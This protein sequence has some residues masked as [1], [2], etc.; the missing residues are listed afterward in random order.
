MLS[1][2]LLYQK[3]SFSKRQAVLLWDA[4][5]DKI[6]PPPHTKLTHM[7]TRRYHATFWTGLG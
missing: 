2:L 1:H 6:R 4:P 7:T 5:V 3:A